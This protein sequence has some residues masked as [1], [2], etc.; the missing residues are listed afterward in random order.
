ML[1]LCKVCTLCSSLG[2]SLLLWDQLSAKIAFTLLIHVVTVITESYTQ[3]HF[4]NSYE[5]KKGGKDQESKQSSTT[6]DPGYHM[7]K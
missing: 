6:P 5:S 2:L 7:G 4:I 3:R 1:H